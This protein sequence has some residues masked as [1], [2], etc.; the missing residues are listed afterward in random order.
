[1]E[2]SGVIHARAVLRKVVCP[3]CEEE[4][5]THAPRGGEVVI[6]SST[7]G[8]F[9]KEMKKKKRV[10]LKRIGTRCLVC[11][12]TFYCGVEMKKEGAHSVSYTREMPSL[13][14]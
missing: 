7:P 8:E 2:K 11:L 6:T 4:T 13:F 1:M 9:L 14:S 5:V 12:G 10:H 3:L